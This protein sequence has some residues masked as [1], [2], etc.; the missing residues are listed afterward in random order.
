MEVFRV[1]CISSHLR[2][3][4][5][6]RVSLLGKYTQTTEHPHQRKSWNLNHWKIISRS[7]LLV[8]YVNPKCTD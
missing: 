4:M 3:F 8:T 2:L 6:T 7:L 5:Q 1:E